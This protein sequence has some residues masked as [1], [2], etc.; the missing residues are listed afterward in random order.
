MNTVLKS[1][2]AENPLERKQAAQTANLHVLFGAWL[3]ELFDGMDASM[4]VL[5]LVPALSELL[6]T[7]APREIGPAAAIVLAT[8]MIGWAFG[9]MFFGYLADKL[10]R[11]RVMTLTILVYALSSGLCA[12]SHSLSE[13]AIYRFFTGFGIGGEITIGAVLVSECWQGAKRLHALSFLTSSFGFGY[14]IAAVL[15]LFVGAI[16]WRLLF[17]AGVL[18]AFL[19]L[20]VRSKI[21]EPKEF[22]RMKD[23]A[24]YL[25]AVHGSQLRVNPVKLCLSRTYRGKVLSIATLATTVIVGYWSALAWIP[26]WVSQIVGGPALAEKS[27]TAIVMNVAAIIFSFLGGFLVHKIGRQRSLQIAFLGSFISIV[28]MF[29]LIKAYGAALLTLVFLVGGFASLPFTIMF[30]YVPEIFPIQARGTAFGISVQTG[31]ICA[32]LACLLGGQI[33]ACFG[34]S[35]GAAGTTIAFIYI[36]G[37]LATFFMPP[38]SGEIESLY[39][40]ELTPV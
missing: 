31:R 13:L 17:L 29:F 7:S 34:G 20:Y 14:L 24:Q 39:E 33:I 26:S 22:K 19:T 1:R 36:F 11:A 35:Y 5:V 16:S 23:L 25:P 8:F 27:F 4:F 32:A 30:I 12:F 28:A 9:A 37:F 40:T 6:K 15:N 2:I 18:P 10:G 21:A 3:G 38:S